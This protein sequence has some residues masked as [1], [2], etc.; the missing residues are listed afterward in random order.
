MT[1]PVSSSLQVPYDLRQAKQV[2]RRMLVDMLQRLMQ[3]GFPIRDYQYTGLGSIFFVDFILLHRVLGLS[4]LWSVEYDTTI[5]RRVRFNKPFSSVQV[6]ISPIGDII[7]IL[8]RDLKHI[9]WL[10]YDFGLNKVV[11][12]DTALA[13][14]NLSPGSL[15]LVTVDVEPP[16]HSK[17]AADTMEFLRDQ[18]GS[19]FESEWDESAFTPAELGQTTAR[20]IFNAIANGVAGRPNTR[21]LTLFNF[22]YKDGHRMITVGG[23]IGTATEQKQLDG[24]DLASADYLRRDPSAPRCEIVVPNMT[25]KERFYLDHHMPCPSG[26]APSDFEMSGE[27]VAEYSKIYR[28]C[29]T[30]AELFL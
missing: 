3:G 10:D 16:A 17:G 28:Y 7:P 30:F 12:A 23:M 22:A 19:F 14:Y 25:R 21:F 9:L 6:F 8:D 5:E 1:S 11:V 13:A 4:R 26:W 29:P 2:E 15:L 18:A 27:D 20:I 24:C